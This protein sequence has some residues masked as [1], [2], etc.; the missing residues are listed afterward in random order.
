MHAIYAWLLW[1]AEPACA[2]PN[3]RMMHPVENMASVPIAGGAHA[4]TR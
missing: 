4:Y 2:A 1:Q 3:A